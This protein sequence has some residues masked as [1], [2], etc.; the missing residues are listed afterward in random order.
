[1]EDHNRGL[2]V[3]TGLQQSP[4]RLGGQVD[5]LH[6]PSVPQGQAGKGIWDWAVTKGS[7]CV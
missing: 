7:S 6:P 3:I 2:Q 5:F 1:M 4:W